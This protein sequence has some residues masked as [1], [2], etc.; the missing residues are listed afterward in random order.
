MIINKQQKWNDN[1]VYCV[2]K[3]V[4]NVWAKISNGKNVKILWLWN[5][6]MVDENIKSIMIC[7]VGHSK[8]YD[9]VKNGNFGNIIWTLPNMLILYDLFYQNKNI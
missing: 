5:Q 1:V 9:H 6:T 7:K 8:R 4:R 3:Y 2:K